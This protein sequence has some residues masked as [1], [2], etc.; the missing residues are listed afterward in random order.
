[1]KLTYIFT[2]LAPLVGASLFSCQKRKHEHQEHNHHEAIERLKVKKALYCELGRSRGESLDW[3]I[4]TCDSSLHAAL[5]AVACGDIPY[6]KFMSDD[7]R[8]HRT[9]T[10]DCYPG[11]GVYGGSKTTVSKDMYRG[12]FLYWLF[13][14]RLDLVNRTIAYGEK[15]SWVMGDGVNEVEIASRTVLSPEMIS[16]IF[17]LQTF[18]EGGA[19]EQTEE[20]RISTLPVKTG[21]PAHL[22]VLNVLFDGKLYGAL[23]DSEYKTLEA[24]SDRQPDNSLFNFAYHRYNHSHPV[25][26]TIAVLENEQY[27]PSERLPTSSDRCQEYLF[28]HDQNE[29]DWS[30]CPEKEHTHVGTDFVFAVSILD[31]TFDKALR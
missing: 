6:E 18:L 8:L 5:W 27:F 12:A 23:T 31:G 14:N 30:P 21:Y 17:D 26:R 4:S 2:L 20:Q 29:K 25:E 19:P 7:G 15:N 22:D 1:M 11:P 13:Y 3:N 9:T 16:Q 24:Q 28:M 10:H